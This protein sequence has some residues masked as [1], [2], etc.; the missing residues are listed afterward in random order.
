MRSTIKGAALGA[1]VMIGMIA[2]RDPDHRISASERLPYVWGDHRVQRS[3]RSVMNAI[4][5]RRCPHRHAIV[6]PDSL[7]PCR[8]SAVRGAATGAGLGGL[9]GFIAAPGGAMLMIV[10]AALNGGRRFNLGRVIGIATAAGAVVGAPIGA[11][12]AYHECK[13]Y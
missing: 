4:A 5:A 11:S 1:G 9:V 8:A 2:I 6:W 13:G 12:R 3:L 10:P 7:R